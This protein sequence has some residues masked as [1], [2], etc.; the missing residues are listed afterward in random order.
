[1]I[2]H[3]GTPPSAIVTGLN[4]NPTPARRSRVRSTFPVAQRVAANPSAPCTFCGIVAGHVPADI[5]HRWD[6]A[7]AIR[8]LDPVNAGHTLVIPTHH[9]DTFAAHPSWSGV[10]A[11]CAA[12]FAAEI[13]DCN[14]IVNVGRDAGQTVFH[15][16]F[17][18]IP[19]TPGDGLLFPWSH[20][21]KTSCGHARE[22]HGPTGCSASPCPCRYAAADMHHPTC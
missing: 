7:I 2:P 11:A 15:L 22:I 14:V 18:L 6:E 4:G 8:P 10:T 17:H 12:E 9:V 3:H 19:R 20:Q 5:V 16:H 1:M 21:E 13:G